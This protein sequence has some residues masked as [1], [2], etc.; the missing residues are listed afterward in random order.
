MANAEP[1]RD[2]AR[3]VNILPRAARALAVRR[4]AVVIELHRDADHVVASAAS[5]AA[6]TD[7]STPPDIATTTRVSAGGLSS[8]K[9]FGAPSKGGASDGASMSIFYW[10]NAGQ[11]VYVGLPARSGKAIA[12]FDQ[13]RHSE[14]GS[15]RRLE[16][17][18]ADRRADD[19]RYSL[20]ASLSANK[21]S[22][23]A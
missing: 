13:P 9:L 10:G 17:V 5:N 22:V 8:P 19:P 12:Q 11:A 21:A 15:C 16:F 23:L 7:K 14:V 2:V 1:R 4:F 20:S 6:V 18:Q 3:I